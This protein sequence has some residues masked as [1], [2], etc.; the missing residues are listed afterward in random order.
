M[1]RLWRS[2]THETVPA[3]TSSWSY[4]HSLHSSTRYFFP[5]THA[6]T[7]THK[8]GWSIRL[9]KRASCVVA[10][11]GCLIYYHHHLTL[12]CTAHTHNQHPFSISTCPGSRRDGTITFHIKA[13][14]GGT[15]TG[16]L[17]TCIR[18]SPDALEGVSVDGGYG[19]PSVDA[20]AYRHVF[21]VSGGIGITPMLSML[22]GF[23]GEQQRLDDEI[24]QE[25]H[26]VHSTRDADALFDM[27]GA[28]CNTTN[29]SQT[30]NT[31]FTQRTDTARGRRRKHN[32]VRFFFH[33]TTTPHALSRNNT[34]G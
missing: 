5:F 11:V 30:H 22:L 21:L 27:F 32:I 33:P 6:H 17:A 26:F 24:P 10:P 25:I 29:T 12:Y 18:T 2:F 8:T 34:E 3:D 23:F 28:V 13:N 4:D 19:L 14:A 9:H 1:C 15:F 31:H 20:R 16:D 7:H